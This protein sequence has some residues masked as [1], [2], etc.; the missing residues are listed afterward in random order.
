MA[1]S[2]AFEL[3]RR[4]AT[5]SLNCSQR[6]RN[7]IRDRLLGRQVDCPIAKAVREALR[8]GPAIRLRR[9]EPRRVLNASYDL[10]GGVDLQLFD[11]PMARTWT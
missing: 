9:L 6:L 8:N 7:R 3:L 5:D 1:S 11:S 4:L 2:R 10:L